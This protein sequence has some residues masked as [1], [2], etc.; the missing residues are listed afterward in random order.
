MNNIARP[1]R[2]VLTLLVF[3]TYLRLT[4]GFVVLAT[5]VEKGIAVHKAIKEVTKLYTKRDVNTALST[6]NRLYIT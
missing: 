6:R 5:I 1:N 3:R 2:L 4:S